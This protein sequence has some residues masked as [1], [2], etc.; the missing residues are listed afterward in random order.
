MPVETTSR[1]N[2]IIPITKSPTELIA[3]TLEALVNN[4][5][6]ARLPD[7]KNDWPWREVSIYEFSERNFKNASMFEQQHDKRA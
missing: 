2:T 5:L 6:A 4:S 3:I 7:L 1:M